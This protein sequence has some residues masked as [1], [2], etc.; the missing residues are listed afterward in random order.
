MSSW[1]WQEQRPHSEKEKLDNLN[2]SM[3]ESKSLIRNFKRDAAAYLQEE[4]A[5]LSGA[6]LTTAHIYPIEDMWSPHYYRRRFTTLLSKNMT[7]SEL[8]ARY[9]EICGSYMGWVLLQ[10]TI[11]YLIKKGYVE[12]LG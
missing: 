10:Q 6:K 1:N 4:Y 11:R 8:G 7:A 3:G 2:K 9:Y 12:E 5:G